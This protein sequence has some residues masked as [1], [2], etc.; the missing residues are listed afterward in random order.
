M[1][2]AENAEW[3]DE[4][5]QFNVWHAVTPLE[6]MP[7]IWL[8]SEYDRVRSLVRAEHTLSIILSS[9][10][11]LCPCSHKR[12]HNVNFPSTP[13]ISDSLRV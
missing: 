5:A 8:V 2:T 11:V 10:A 3:P 4:E 1:M 13:S 7:V 12:A 9:S 6:R